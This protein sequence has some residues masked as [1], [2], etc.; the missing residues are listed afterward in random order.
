MASRVSNEPTQWLLPHLRCIVV[1]SPNKAWI[2]GISSGTTPTTAGPAALTTSPSDHSALLQTLGCVT[3]LPP[4]TPETHVN[5]V[6]VSKCGQC[7][8]DD[9][10]PYTHTHT[11]THTRT[12]C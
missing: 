9:S 5:R 7:R 3:S 11:H 4:I 10:S 12:T 6:H 8:H 2:F 1:V